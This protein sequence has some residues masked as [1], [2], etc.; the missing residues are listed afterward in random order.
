MHVEP[1]EPLFRLKIPGM[2]LDL[3]LGTRAGKFFF[4]VLNTLN[5]QLGYL[6]RSA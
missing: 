2:V 1:S 4:F 5:D 3:M 6:D